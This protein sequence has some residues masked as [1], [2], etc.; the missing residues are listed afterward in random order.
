MITIVNYG[1]G[2]PGAIVN[3][4]DFIG[5]DARISDD[6][7]EIRDASHL[8]LPGVGAFDAAMERLSTSRLVPSL[9]DAVFS[10]KVPLLGVCLGMQLLGRRSEEGV[11]KGLGWIAADTV[12]M[13]PDPA[14]R[15]KV[16]VM[17]WADI[18]PA[19]TAR[20]FD[21]GSELR[22]YF[23][24]SYMVRCDDQA[25][26]AG[27]YDFDEAVVCAVQHDNIY[28]VQFH[29]EKSHRFGMKLLRTFIERTR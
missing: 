16:P 25:D 8:V 26:V 3:M 23:T 24:H 27:T 1:V 7:S 6:P 15:L 17:G 13:R 29:P 4:L 18:H 21:A 12:R 2:N 9:E 11:L 5:F 10:R 22:F 20:L 14:A 19:S 28:G